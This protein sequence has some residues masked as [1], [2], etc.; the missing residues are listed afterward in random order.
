MSVFLR[1]DMR[2]PPLLGL[3]GYTRPVLPC[4]FN[5]VRWHQRA[6]SLLSAMK[7][8]IFGIGCEGPPKKKGPKARTPKG[9]Q[10]ENVPCLPDGA[11]QQF[12]TVSD[13][14]VQ[15]RQYI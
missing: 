13:I 14:E 11:C 5:C 7:Q 12:Q 3:L 15:S 6:A 2:G 10:F 4:F 1:P 9:P 8:C